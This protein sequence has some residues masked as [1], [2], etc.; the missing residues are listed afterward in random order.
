MGAPDEAD[1]TGDADEPP[2]DGD[3]TGDA[4]GP[5]ADE[6]PAMIAA[7]ASTLTHLETRLLIP[8]TPPTIDPSV[9]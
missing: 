3:G 1:E 5:P 8:A 2:D 4:D 7:V 6:Q 9:G